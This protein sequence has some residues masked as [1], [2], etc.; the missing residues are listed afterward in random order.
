[1]LPEIHSYLKELRTHLNLEPQTERRV[2]SELYS[3]FQ[4]K[5]AELRDLGYS[6][7][8][9]AREAIS[10][11]GN[12]RLVARL[13][14]EACSR[15]TWLEAL[16]SAQ[17]HLIAAALFATHFWRYPFFLAGAFALLAC[18]TFLAWRRGRPNWVYSWVGYVL[19]SLLA[20]AYIARRLAA[21]A[22]SFLLAGEGAFWAL[23][24]LLPLAALCAV[25]LWLL[26][27]ITLKALRRDWLL[28][29]LMLIPLPLAG[30]WLIH[31]ERL[32]PLIRTLGA[33]PH[34][35]DASMAIVFTVLALVS[36][37]FVRL[38]QRTFK[39]GALLAIGTIGAA[40]VVR[41]IWNQISL[42]ALTLVALLVLG[43]F[44]SPA[45]FTRLGVARKESD[46]PEPENLPDNPPVIT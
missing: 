11:F 13:L 6:E 24:P 16:I 10:C 5:M 1:M 27:A 19:F 40:V 14:Y 36:A 12:A 43:F 29:S 39:I 45:L 3:H 2:L 22:L 38:R 20:G 44:W 15:G 41:T 34:R 23:W 30:I 32:V 42:F 35:W 37:L 26:T 8:E 4:E 21:P 18:A 46:L 33:D 31:V 28:A 9:A 25:T 17:P 7:A